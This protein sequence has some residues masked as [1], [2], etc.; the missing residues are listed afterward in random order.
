[1]TETEFDELVKF[2]SDNNIEVP[3]AGVPL[4]MTISTLQFAI[5]KKWI[6]RPD[7]VM[8]HLELKLEYFNHVIKKDG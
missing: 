7:A 3:D 5:K 1:M 4:D 2:L 8:D 6:P